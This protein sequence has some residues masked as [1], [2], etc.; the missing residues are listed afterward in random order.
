M[1]FSTYCLSGL[2]INWCCTAADKLLQ[3]FLNILL[4]INYYGKYFLLHSLYK[5]FDGIW[6]QHH[7]PF[8]SDPSWGYWGW[9]RTKEGGGFS[10]V[11]IWIEVGRILF[12]KPCSKL[13]RNFLAKQLNSEKSLKIESFSF[14]CEMHD[15]ILEWQK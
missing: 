7:S 10:G 8:T 9:G 12:G 13:L 11:E 15:L 14:V 6:T 5:R 4:W 2:V 1:G 3:V